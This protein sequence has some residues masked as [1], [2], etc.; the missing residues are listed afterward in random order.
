V[1][2]CLCVLNATK[3]CVLISIFVKER[4]ASTGNLLAPPVRVPSVSETESR[5]PTKDKQ[6]NLEYED[7]RSGENMDCG[8]NENT[9]PNDLDAE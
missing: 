7:N 9:E 4:R 2:I 8:N 5:P 6:N 1:F 3:T